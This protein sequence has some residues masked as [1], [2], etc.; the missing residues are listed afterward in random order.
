[1]DLPAVRIV[2]E[3]AIEISEETLDLEKRSVISL[4]KWMM[5]GD[6]LSA[7]GRGVEMPPSSTAMIAIVAEG[8][9][10]VA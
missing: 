6:G 4:R 1:M 7:S 8:H 2:V 9:G 10:I 3:E 5:S